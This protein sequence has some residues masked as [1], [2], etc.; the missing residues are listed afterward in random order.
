[1]GAI[2]L[3]GGVKQN[4]GYERQGQERVDLGGGVPL[5]W[6]RPRTRGGMET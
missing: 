3:L 1:M 4:R 5:L 6:T 2:F